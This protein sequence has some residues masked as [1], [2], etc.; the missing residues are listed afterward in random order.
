MSILN[1]SKGAE[2]ATQVSIPSIITF[3][4]S[5]SVSPTLLHTLHLVAKENKAGQSFSIC[6]LV[7]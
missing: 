4:L 3:F 7:S 2:W 1:P 6:F 5:L